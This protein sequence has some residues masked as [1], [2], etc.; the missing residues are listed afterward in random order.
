V[1]NN[2]RQWRSLKVRGDAP[3]LQVFADYSPESWWETRYLPTTE[4]PESELVTSTFLSRN[5]FATQISLGL[6]DAQSAYVLFHARTITYRVY[7]QTITGF[8][9]VVPVFVVP[10]LKTATQNPV[11][12]LPEWVDFLCAARS[13]LCKLA[14]EKRSD[15]EGFRSMGLPIPGYF[16]PLYSLPAGFRAEGHKPS[17]YF[18]LL[19]CGCASPD[20]DIL[21]RMLQLKSSKFNQK[22][23]QCVLSLDEGPGSVYETYRE[24]IVSAASEFLSEGRVVVWGRK[25]RRDFLRDVSREIDGVLSLQNHHPHHHSDDSLSYE[26]FELGI[27]VYSVE[28]G[29]LIPVD[30]PS[31]ISTRKKFRWAFLNG[32]LNG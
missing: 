9:G 14:V 24:G 7:S 23:V 20:R 13:G 15:S 10:G 2:L 11:I 18:R 28:D 26:A 31:D 29:Q 21:S 5:G 6:M 19:I 1:L 17:E 30:Q 32:L 27:P 12:P 25:R 8:P 3:I 22:P 4:E 16:P